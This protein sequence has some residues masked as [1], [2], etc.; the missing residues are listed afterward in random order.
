[1]KACVHKNFLALTI[2][3]GR[4]CQ[5]WLSSW[6]LSVSLFVLNMRLNF[7]QIMQF[8]PHC[9]VISV[10]NLSAAKCRS[11]WFAAF[12]TEMEPSLT[13]R[14]S[15]V[16]DWWNAILSI[17]FP[18]FVRYFRAKVLRFYRSLARILGILTCHREQCARSDVAPTSPWSIS[19]RFVMPLSWRHR[20]MSSYSVTSPV[21]PFSCQSH[22]LFLSDSVPNAYL[23]SIRKC[24]S[25]IMKAGEPI[26][27]SRFP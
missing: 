10:R 8:T 14:T 27:V 22:S 9:S 16:S 19:C 17:N 5:Q 2:F 25:Q 6:Q 24:E 11:N 23:Y 13:S 18:P 21:M 15:V 26:A 20:F 7:Y 3:Y 12:S 4:P 1:M